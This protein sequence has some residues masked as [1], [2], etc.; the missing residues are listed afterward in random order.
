MTLGIDR[1][2][3]PSIGEDGRVELGQVADSG[4]QAIVHEL[5]HLKVPNHGRLF[6]AL[7]RA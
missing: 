2:A 1:L 4:A 6:R 7:E 5:P 3:I